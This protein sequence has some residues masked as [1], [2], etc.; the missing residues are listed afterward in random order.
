MQTKISFA[1]L[2]LM[3]MASAAL[4]QP[5]EAEKQRLIQQALKANEPGEHHQRLN[6]FVGSWATVWRVWHEPN[7]KPADEAKG[8]AR[9]AWIHNKRFLRG[10]YNGTGMMRRAYTSELLLGY[11]NRHGHY[12]ATWANSFETATTS[13]AGQP[14]LN[15]AGRFTGFTLT[16]KADDCPT[17]RKDVTYRSVF[18]FASN[19]RIVE[20]VFGP[21]VNGREFKVTEVTY[22]RLGRSAKGK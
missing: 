19:D 13:Y 5:S 11:N 17:G 12:E 6:A 4:A 18:T 22:T 9:F 8:T 15:A 21:D 16:G 2:L 10:S 20:E 3:T 14:N 1:F 7:S